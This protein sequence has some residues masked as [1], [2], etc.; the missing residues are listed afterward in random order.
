MV[1]RRLLALALIVVIAGIGVWALTTGGGPERAGRPAAEHG[2]EIALQDDAVFPPRLYYD[3]SL[4]YRQARELG[5]S[6][7]RITVTW[8]SVA[9]SSAHALSPPASVP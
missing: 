3:S 1:T 5:V 4:A 7:L 2:L 9:G 6:W 8:S